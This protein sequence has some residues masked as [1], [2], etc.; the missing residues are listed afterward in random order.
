MN[1]CREDPMDQTTLHDHNPDDWLDYKP[2]APPEWSD[3]LVE[4]ESA[5]KDFSAES[6]APVIQPPPQDSSTISTARSEAD[7]LLTDSPAAKAISSRRSYGRSATTAPAQQPTLLPNAK[8]LDMFPAFMSRS[9]LFGAFRPNCGGVHAGPLNA[10]GAVE[11]TFN[12]PRLCMEDKRVWEALIRIAKRDQVDIAAPFKVRLAEVAQL[13]GYGEGQSRSAYGAIERLASCRLDAV[14]YGARMSGW[15]LMSSAKDGRHAT[16]RLDPALAAPALSQTMQAAVLPPP[17]SSQPL[18]KAARG[19]GSNGVGSLLAQWLR[20]YLSTH[21]PPAKSLT[22]GY[23]RRL[24]GYVSEAK[25]FVSA[26]EN[27]MADLVNFRPDLVASW[28]IDKSGDLAQTEARAHA[29]E[30]WILLIVRGPAQPVVKHPPKA[31]CAVAP[32][33]KSPPKRR[34]GVSL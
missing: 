16:V 11:L 3:A 15:M 18:S 29:S 23:L 9:A 24:S 17:A 21:K 25:H 27:A 20:D 12:G 8:D 4:E 22:L 33:A 30:R 6:T 34:G 5:P 7:A 14:V 31:A 2:S 28:S 32:Q 26:L 13:A 1:I 10:A 19:A